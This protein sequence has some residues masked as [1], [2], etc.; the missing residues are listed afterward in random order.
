MPVAH[1]PEVADLG[2]VTPVPGGPPQLLGIR[3]LRGE[4]VPVF[5]LAGV[6]AVAGTPAPARI[7]LADDGAGH[8]CALAVDEVVEV[9]EI[10]EAPEDVDSPLL[11]G[12][13]LIDGRL[14]GVVDVPALLASIA[15]T[16]GSA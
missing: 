5:D 12:A 8:R 2:D 15:T 9:S 1:V 4:V 7:A 11:R 16:G 10:E 14:V 3:N 13:A 6:L